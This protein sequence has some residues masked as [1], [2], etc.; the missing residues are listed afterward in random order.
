MR[1]ECSVVLGNLPLRAH[2]FP[3]R[4]FCNLIEPYRLKFMGPIDLFSKFLIEILLSFTVK[5][6]QFS[7]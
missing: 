7:F 1:D 6:R 5:I 3:L 2:R 4:D